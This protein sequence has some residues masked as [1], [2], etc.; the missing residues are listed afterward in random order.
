[1]GKRKIYPQCGSNSVSK[2]LYGLID[3]V[4][5]EDVGENVVL[6]G[7]YTS[8]NSPTLQCNRCKYEWGG[9]KELIHR[10]SLKQALAGISVHVATF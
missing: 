4:S 5:L 3:A 8:E 1:L 2:I 10:W 6:G 9:M 7:C